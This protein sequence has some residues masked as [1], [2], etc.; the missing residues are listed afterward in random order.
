[1][2]IDEIIKTLTWEK[3]SLECYC[4]TSTKRYKEVCRILEVAIRTKGA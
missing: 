2:E 4:K 3:L 1:M